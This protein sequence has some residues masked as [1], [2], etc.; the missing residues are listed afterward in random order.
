[1]KAGRP[2]LKVLG[3]S[4]LTVLGV[5]VVG[6]GGAHAAEYL[7]EEG[8][9]TKTFNQHGIVTE[10]VSGTFGETE[11]LTQKIKVFCHGA[12]P[13]GTLITGGTG[14]FKILFDTCEVLENSSCIV[15]ETEKDHKEKMFTGYYQISGT[16]G[17]FLHAGTHYI[18]IEGEP[19]GVIWFGDNGKKEC[20]LPLSLTISGTFALKTPNVLTLSVLQTLQTTTAAEETSLETLFPEFGLFLG[21]SEAHYK[22]GSTG[23]I[24]LGGA[25]AGKK[26][27]AH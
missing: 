22:A 3:L 18:W 1:M 24:S 15:Y 23:S 4:L 25:L 2:C 9:V 11:L 16:G 5:M 26:W 19:L 27:G 8:G 12:T 17:I 7:I 13:T 14:K 10:T 20:T 21:A 6:A